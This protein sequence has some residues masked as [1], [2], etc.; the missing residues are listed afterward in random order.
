[1]PIVLYASNEGSKPGGWSG[2]DFQGVEL[3]DILRFW[4]LSSAMEERAREDL[5]DREVVIPGGEAITRRRACSRRAERS[6]QHQSAQHET[7]L[8]RRLIIL[9]TTERHNTDSRYAI[10]TYTIETVSRWGCPAD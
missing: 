6:Q 3:L 2:P 7:K 5:G 4:R 9:T 1:M 8:L 10:G